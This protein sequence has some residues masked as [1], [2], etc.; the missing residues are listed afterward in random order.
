MHD[1]SHCQL[2]S[3]NGPQFVADEFQKFAK[4]WDIEHLTTSPY[5]GKG[6]GKGEDHQEA[7][8]QDHETGEDQYLRLLSHRNTHTEGVDRSPVQR[9]ISRRTRTLLPTAN[10]LLQPRSISAK[11]E[12]EKKEDVQKKQVHYYDRNARNLPILDK[13]ETVRMKL[14]TLDTKEWKKAVVMRRL[15]ERSYEVE[16]ADGASYRRNR[17]HLRMTKEP[18][19]ST[20]MDD[21]P[22]GMKGSSRQHKTD[23]LQS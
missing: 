17:A 7:A 15:Y 10:N 19:P 23:L 21:T 20:N 3:D 16:T 22:G 13:G 4:S 2:V 8:P 12:R 5:K 9:L 6:N 1:D 18:P 11:H 14:F